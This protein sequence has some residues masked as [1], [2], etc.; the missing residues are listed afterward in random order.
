MIIDVSPWAYW[1]Y[2][3]FAGLGMGATVGWIFN[4]IS[5]LFRKRD[6]PE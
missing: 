2:V 6:L 4:Y 3:S 1:I 5:K